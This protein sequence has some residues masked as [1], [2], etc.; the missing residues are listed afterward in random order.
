MGSLAAVEALNEIRCQPAAMLVKPP[1][2]KEQRRGQIELSR[3]LFVFARRMGGKIHG[4]NKPVYGPSGVV[5]LRIIIT[6]SINIMK[7]KVLLRTY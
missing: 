5:L 7:I 6:V 3:C 1:R 4:Q 2:A